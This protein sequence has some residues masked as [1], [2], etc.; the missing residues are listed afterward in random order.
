[1]AARTWKLFKVICLI[2]VC[3]L[4][5]VGLHYWFVYSFFLLS[6]LFHVCGCLLFELRMMKVVIPYDHGHKE[7]YNA[8]IM[9]TKTE[10]KTA[11]F[12]AK[13]TE[14]DRRQNI[15]NR[16]N[17]TS[18]MYCANICII[19][20]VTPQYACR[21]N[22]PFTSTATISTLQSTKARRESSS[23]TVNQFRCFICQLLY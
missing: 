18:I 9:R 22:P 10:P 13:P 20:P 6:A 1:M 21:Q 4:T 5:S 2:S 12:L 16:N 14:T 17:I 15:W 19:S 23:L 8:F 11:V 3:S 7:V